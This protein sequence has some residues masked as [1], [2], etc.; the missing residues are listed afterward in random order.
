[1]V[2]LS[3]TAATQSQADEAALRPGPLGRLARV[4]FRNRGRTVL[5]WLAALVVAAG[6]STAFAGS[7]SVEPL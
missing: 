3:S 7:E 5:I 4:T 2:T 1:M 6:L